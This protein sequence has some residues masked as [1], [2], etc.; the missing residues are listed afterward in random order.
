MRDIRS[1]GI[2]P[3]VSAS[4]LE[5]A[6]AASADMTMIDPRLSPGFDYRRKC[7]DDIA[8]FVKLDDGLV[9]GIPGVVASAHPLEVVNIIVSLVFVD[10]VN[11]FQILRILDEGVSD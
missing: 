6:A 3:D 2:L 1:S 9:A 4:C 5:L 8:V 11:S 7:R 10:M